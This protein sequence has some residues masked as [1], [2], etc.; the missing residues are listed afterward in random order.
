MKR[1][2]DYIICTTCGKRVAVLQRSIWAYKKVKHN[3]MHYFCSWKCLRAWEQIKEVKKEG[4]AEM[5]RKLTLEQ[6]KKAVQIAIDGGDPIEFLRGCGSDAPDKTWW[7]IK[8]RKKDSNP[9][10][11]A[12]IP[13]GRK[14]GN[15]GKRKKTEAKPEQKKKNENEKELEGFEVVNVQEKK[16][17]PP[18]TAAAA[19]NIKVMTVSVGRFIIDNT[20]EGLLIRGDDDQIIKIK[21]DEIKTLVQAL[22]VALNLF[23]A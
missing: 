5:A 20:G 15:Q 14:R 2:N 3:V 9:D 21:Y 17:Q 4:P 16:D 11:Y 6:K 19:P 7:Y 22:P 18:W 23:R 12:K 13:D 1:N 10:L 8:N